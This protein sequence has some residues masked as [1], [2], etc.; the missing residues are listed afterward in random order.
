MHNNNNNNN[1]SYGILITNFLIRDTPIAFN[2]SCD[3]LKSS[4]NDT[5][6]QLSEL[7]SKQNELNIHHEVIIMMIIVVIISI[8]K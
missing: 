6:A 7:D 2:Q 8:D 1:I 3:E 4:I 5:L